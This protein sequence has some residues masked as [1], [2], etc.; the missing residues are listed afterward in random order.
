MLVH[1]IE[2]LLEESV[3]LGIG[4][5]TELQEAITVGVA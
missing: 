1:I 5:F 3:R 4:I 2:V